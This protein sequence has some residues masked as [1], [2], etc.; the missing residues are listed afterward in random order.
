MSSRIHGQRSAMATALQQAG[1]HACTTAHDERGANHLGERVSELRV[2]RQR[3]RQ[4]RARHLVRAGYDG[5]KELSIGQSGSHMVLTYF[6]G[7]NYRR[8]A[9]M[10]RAPSDVRTL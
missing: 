1:T 4:R 5:P 2:K 3:G 7:S 10:P 6:V 9:K 8:P